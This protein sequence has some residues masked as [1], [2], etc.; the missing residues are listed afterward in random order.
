MDYIANIDPDGNN[1]VVVGLPD[2][3]FLPAYGHAGAVALIDQATIGKLLSENALNLTTDFDFDNFEQ[4][5]NDITNSITPSKIH[6]HIYNDIGL[7]I[8]YGETFTAE[9]VRLEFI[10]EQNDALF[11]SFYCS[12]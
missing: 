9:K 7:M 8:G 1:V 4:F 11:N 3:T 6:L 2:R 5:A 10:Q 12:F